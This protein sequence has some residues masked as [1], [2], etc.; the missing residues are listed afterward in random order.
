MNEL[1]PMSKEAE[2]RTKLYIR[3]LRH[4]SEPRHLRLALAQF[5][6]LD[7]GI[8]PPVWHTRMVL[9]AWIEFMEERLGIQSAGAKRIGRKPSQSLAV[10]S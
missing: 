9:R 10:A 7:L 3:M 1:R 8:I 4:R 5:H 2:A 6:M